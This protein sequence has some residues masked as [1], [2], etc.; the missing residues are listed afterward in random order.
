MNRCP[1]HAAIIGGCVPHSRGDEPRSG[2][3]RIDENSPCLAPAAWRAQAA[4]VVGT[5]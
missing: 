4:R 3:L 5:L 1:A 2:V